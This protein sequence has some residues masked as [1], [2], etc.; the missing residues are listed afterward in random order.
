MRLVEDVVLRARRLVDL[1]LECVKLALCGR[2]CGQVRRTHVPHELGENS[3][4]PT[5]SIRL[6]TVRALPR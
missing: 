4:S 5:V 2:A 6:A 3:L 1:G